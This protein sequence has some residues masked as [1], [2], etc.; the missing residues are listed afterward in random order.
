MSVQRIRTA[1]SCATEARQAVREFHAAVMQPDGIELVIFF[2]SSQYDLDVLAAEM[3]HLFAGIQ[4]LGCTTAG[5]IGPAGYRTYSLSGASFPAGSCVAV[6]GLLD[7]LKQFNFARGYDFAQAL[8]QRLESRAPGASPDNSFAFMLI[9]GMSGHEEPVAHALQHALGKIPTFGGSAGDDQKFLSTHVFS[10]GYFH[11]GGA[12]L[13]LLSTSLP[14]HLFVTHHFV[15][16]DEWLVVTEAD[17]AQRIVKEIN[18]LPAATEYAR[19][20]G[21]DASA[22]NPVHFA[23]SPLVVMMDGTDY[24][25]AIQKANAD[26]SL[27]FMCAIEEGLVLRVAHGGDMVNNLEQTFDNLR[28]EIGPPQLVIACDCILRKLEV[29]QDGLQDRVD[30]IFR[31]NNTLGFSSYGEQIHGVHVNQTLT[32][33]AI[34]MAPESGQ[35]SHDA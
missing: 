4:V 11:A 28:L 30:A 27:T 8:L 20:L 14:F 15:S 10:D 34:G 26:G 21:V 24:V 25:R 33:I 9:D 22:L 7:H 18:G 32:G 35:E 23:A 12:V 17:T 6:S 31:R 29:S 2:C 16:T 1:Q 19:M 5:E 13:V 3:R